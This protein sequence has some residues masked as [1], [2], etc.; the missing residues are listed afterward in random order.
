MSGGRSATL[1]MTGVTESSSRPKRITFVA[2]AIWLL[3]L[4]MGFATLWAG[5]ATS[6]IQESA[7]T[8]GV[9]ATPG[10]LLLIHAALIA[11]VAITVGYASVGALLAGRAGAGRIAALLLAGGALFALVPFGYAVG[12]T[13]TFNQPG[14]RLFDAVLLLGPVAI[15]PGYAAIL[16]SLALAFP[17]GRLPSRRWQWPVGVAVGVVGVGT[18][19]QLVQPGA[20]VGATGGPRPNPFGLEALPAALAALAY[21]AVAIGV[22]GLTVLGI[23]AVVTRYRRG[24]PVARQQL[25][26]FLAAVSLAAVPFAL[27]FV[28][29]TGGLETA[30]VA[31]IGLM[32]VPFAVGIAVTRYRLYEID[33]LINRTLVYVPLTALL[34]G[35]YAATVTLLQ[36]VFQSVTGDRSDAAIIISTLVLASVFTPLRKWLEGIVERRFKP[37]P[38]GIHAGPMDSPPLDAA[39][40]EAR[41]A[42]IALGVVR[43]ELD[44]RSVRTLQRD[45]GGAGAGSWIRARRYGGWTTSQTSHRGPGSPRA[46]RA[47]VQHY[48]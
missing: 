36:R 39:G 9:I 47:G 48:G 15:G 29:G 28:P 44:A 37:V 10:Q 35:L 16:P 18:F 22:V 8:N 6:F 24:E 41:V 23:I 26:W 25:R 14:S 27:I 13:L 21:P 45:L 17:D 30:L 4:F 2:R 1:R 5:V 33:H 40:W 3:T 42:A 32:L 38:S 20:L 34:A 7:A 11:I 31:A 19:L 43:T 12:G 46:S